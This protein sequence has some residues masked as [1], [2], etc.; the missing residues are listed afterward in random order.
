VSGQSDKRSAAI[1]SGDTAEQD[2]EVVGSPAAESGEPM[3]DVQSVPM[4]RPTPRPRPKPGPAPSPGPT[5][6]ATTAAPATTGSPTGELARPTRGPWLSSPVARSAGTVI[7]DRYRLLAQTGADKTVHAEFWRARDTVLERDVALTLLQET[8]ESGQ[9][10]RATN[11]I[12]RALRFGRFENAGCARL[13]DV[14]RNDNGGLP[15]DVLG[16]AVT[17]W[18]PGRSIAEAV[19]R[20]PLRTGAVLSMLDPL[21][22]A[23]EAAHR[24]GLVLG[25]PH[26]QRVRITPEGKARL[27]FALP[28]P[29]ITPADDVRGLG[30]LLYALLTARWPLSG[31]DAAMAGLAAAPRDPRGVAVPPT[32]V[33]PG[34]SVEVSALVQGALGAGGPH[35]QVLTAAGVH[36]VITELL[37]AEQEAA[38][39]PPPDDGAPVDP[40][41]VWRVDSVPAP[42]EPDR[43]RKLKYGM[44][45]LGVGMVVVIAYVGVQVGSLL[46]VTGSS[47]PRITVTSPVASAPAAAPASAAP[48]GVAPAGAAPAAAAPAGAAPAAAAPSAPGQDSAS[49]DPEQDAAPDASREAVVH[50]AAVRVFDPSGDPDNAGRV[51]RVVDDDPASNWSTYIYRRP[52]P[53]LKSGVGIMVSFASPVQLSTLTINSPSPGSEI[54]IRSAPAPDA[55]F[56]QTIPIGSTTIQGDR[57]SVSLTGSQPVQN[58]LVWITKL[59]GGDDQN[60]TVISDLRFERVTG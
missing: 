30:A 34:I 4:H 2:A 55:T 21:A 9:S 60:V 19:S 15:D 45:G 32:A 16:L 14:M 17:E 18:V 6:T 51:G 23:A 3:N 56:G 25:C 40:D 53:A 33:R 5:A 57:T 47:A 48:A 58:V 11:M 46:G 41:E 13:L 22:Q 39:L 35:G 28:H 26:P 42:E 29:D 44:A 20:G 12:S 49:V 36:K 1:L 52:F 7:A 50:P 27:A 31:T 38:L 24:Q 43:T 8:G 54:E 37:E 59:G 10:A